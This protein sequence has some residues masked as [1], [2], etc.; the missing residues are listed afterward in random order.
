MCDVAPLTG[1]TGLRGACESEER[2]HDGPSCRGRAA[3]PE[4]QTTTATTPVPRGGVLAGVCQSNQRSARALGPLE[5]EAQHASSAAA[6]SAVMM[7]ID[8]LTH[9]SCTYIQ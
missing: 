5:E 3:A 2:R 9:D 1:D 7:M 6:G 4:T 8:R